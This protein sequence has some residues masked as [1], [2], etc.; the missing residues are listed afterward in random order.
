M[1]E[2]SSMF[3][4]RL[5]DHQTL[6]LDIWLSVFVIT[7]MDEITIQMENIRKGSTFTSLRNEKH[8]V[9]AKIT[10]ELTLYFLHAFEHRLNLFSSSYFRKRLHR[11]KYIHSMFIWIDVY[12][13][14]CWS[15]EQII[16]VFAKILTCTSSTGKVIDEKL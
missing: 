9:L 14:F 7:D 11:V 13:Y 8:M 12:S 5:T 16:R 2:V 6:S 3:I 4:S 15:S 10:V 1:C